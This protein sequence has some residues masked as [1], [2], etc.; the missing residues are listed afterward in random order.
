MDAIS[1]DKKQLEAMLAYQN[2]DVLSRFMD[3]F[4][5]THEEAKELFQET[6]KFLFVCQVKGVFIPDDLLILDEMWHNFILFTKEYQ[7]FCNTHFDTYF[8]HL[9]ASKVEKEEQR[10]KNTE[11]PEGSRNEY[12][13]KLRYILSITYDTLGKET[14]QKWFKIYP[15]KYSKENIKSLRKI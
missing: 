6:K 7:A 3:M 12:L 9:P 8:H 5:V 1:L 15:I 11:D 10:K 14:V 4:D 13:E 2:E